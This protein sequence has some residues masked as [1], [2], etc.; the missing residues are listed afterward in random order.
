[1]RRTLII[2]LA[3]VLFSA[4]TPPTPTITPRPTRTPIPVV[5]LIVTPEATFT[6]PP[7]WTLPPT[8]T[9]PSTATRLPSSTPL[10]TNTT[11]PTRTPAGGEIGIVTTAGLL[12]VAVDVAALNAA[13]RAERDTFYFSADFN[14]APSAA[15]EER[16]AVISA[17]L[18]DFTTRG[19]PV[20]FR[21][22]FRAVGGEFAVE[23]LGFESA[24]RAPIPPNQVSLTRELVRRALRDRAVPEAIRKV[25]P[26]MSEYTPLDVQMQANRVLFTVRITQTTPTPAPD[27]ATPTP[28]E[29]PTPL[30]EATPTIPLTRTPLP[31]TTPRSTP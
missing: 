21:L 4:C 22:Q 29:T 11:I 27:T 9:P 12:T 18:N 1:M 25:A 2:L 19:L 13:L 10:P 14:G 24:T 8:L 3:A 7:T 23:V 5:T 30:I 15:L 6:L 17:N 16:I 20:T 28:S 26:L 31:T